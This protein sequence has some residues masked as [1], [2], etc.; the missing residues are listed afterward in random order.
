MNDE[1]KSKFKVKNSKMYHPRSISF[2]PP[3]TAFCINLFN[4]DFPRLEMQVNQTLVSAIYS[5][6]PLRS[7]DGE[8]CVTIVSETSVRLNFVGAKT[9]SLI[10]GSLFFLGRLLRSLSVGVPELFRRA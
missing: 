1:L 4:S 10:V 2:Q 7:F 8:M 3:R 5:R 6:L 9:K